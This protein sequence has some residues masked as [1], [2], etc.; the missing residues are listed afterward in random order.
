MDDFDWIIE[1]GPN[2][3]PVVGDTIKVI[4]VG[5]EKSFRRWLGDY[6]DRYISGKYGESIV[7]LVKLVTLDY[8][9]I[10]EN[11]TGDYIQFPIINENGD[12]IRPSWGDYYPGLKVFYEYQ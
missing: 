6:R 9:Q 7:G 1:L 3:T 5:E 12:P 11:S 4:N 10:K 8:I 2:I